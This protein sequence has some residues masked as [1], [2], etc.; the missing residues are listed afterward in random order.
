MAPLL[1]LRLFYTLGMYGWFSSMALILHRQLGWD[2]AQ[3]SYVFA[4]FGVLQVA[5]QVGVVGRLVDAIGNRMATNLGIVLCRAL[6]VP[7]RFAAVYAPGLDPMDFHAVFEAWHDGAWWAYDATNLVPRQ[8]LVRVAT[9]RDAAD[10]SF[11]TVTSGIATLIGLRVTA[12]SDGALPAD[13]HD[14]PLGLA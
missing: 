12:T 4:A 13:T 11:A 8:T 14:V 1:W 2:V 6:G 9:G 5:L 3:M 10:T 7:A